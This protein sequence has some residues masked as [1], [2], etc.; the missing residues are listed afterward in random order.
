MCLAFR[1]KI[2]EKKTEVKFKEK[3]PYKK[4]KS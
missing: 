1:Y 4:Q 2:H 3:N